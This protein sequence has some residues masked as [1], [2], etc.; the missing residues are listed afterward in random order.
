MKS[1]IYVAWNNRTNSVQG[2]KGP[3]WSQPEPAELFAVRNTRCWDAWLWGWLWIWPKLWGG[4]Q[5]HPGA[6]K[7]NRRPLY[8]M[9]F[10]PLYWHWRISHGAATPWMTATWCLLWHQPLLRARDLLHRCCDTTAAQLL[11]CVPRAF[12]WS[13]EGS[14]WNCS[15]SEAWGKICFDFSKVGCWSWSLSN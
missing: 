3:F 8:M 7:R 1:D 15:I 12:P 9:Y 13:T 5:I 10:A 4:C 6:L 2:D 11:Q 14:G